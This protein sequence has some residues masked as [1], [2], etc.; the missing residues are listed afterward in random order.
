[1]LSDTD[2][3]IEKLDAKVCAVAGTYRE[4]IAAITDMCQ[5]VSKL[6]ITVDSTCTQVQELNTFRGVL[7]ELRDLKPWSDRSRRQLERRLARD[8]AEL[9]ERVEEWET[10]VQDLEAQL[11]SGVDELACRVRQLEVQLGAPPRPDDA[12]SVSTEDGGGWM[13]VVESRG[14][15]TS[16]IARLAHLEAELPRMEDKLDN[17]LRRCQQELYHVREGRRSEPFLEAAR[18]SEALPR[19]RQSLSTS[20]SLTQSPTDLQEH[21]QD[22]ERCPASTAQATK[23]V[24]RNTTT[25]GRAPA[26][27]HAA[28]GS[29]AEDGCCLKVGAP[30]E[31]GLAALDRR[32]AHAEH[33][34]SLGGAHEAAIV[35]AE[36]LDV[37]AETL[38]RLQAATRRTE[39][40]E[41][42]LAAELD[43]CQETSEAALRDNRRAIDRFECMVLRM[44][45]LEQALRSRR[46]TE[47]APRSACAEG[48][49]PACLGGAQSPSSCM[50]RCSSAPES[51]CHS[52]RPC[53]PLGQQTGPATCGGQP[54]GATIGCASGSFP[55][56]PHP[57]LRMPPTRQ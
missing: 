56:R 47:G 40:L 17:Q 3:R 23:E 37:L 6:S 16:L 5:Q 46:D 43:R 8:L 11:P 22:L 36:L 50:S 14:A 9:A 33:L 53:P 38:R 13:P 12:Q 49:S 32:L 34:R 27:G 54:H 26:T 45:R 52:T 55:L 20:P 4:L 48:A 19:S 57:H 29:T 39:C 7:L 1:M 18:S 42:E 10:R 41:L 31:G 2:I 44:D 15:K 21:L 25:R 24:A 28:E 51:C 35:H 30:L